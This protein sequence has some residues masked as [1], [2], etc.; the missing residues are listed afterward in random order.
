MSSDRSNCKYDVCLSFA[1]E[2]R[3][4]VEEVA[5]QARSRN[6][7]VFYD[8]YE[9]VEL[10][11]KNLYKHLA[12]VYQNQARFC[13]IFI[14]E[15]YARKLW[16]DHELSSAQARAFQEHEDYLLPVRFDDTEIPGV[17]RTIGY[18]NGR[19]VS[20]EKLADM[21]EQRVMSSSRAQYFPDNP[22]GLYSHL[23]VNDTEGQINISTSANN[24]FRSLKLM[25]PEELDVVVK[26][27]LHACPGE[28]PENVHIQQDLLSRLTG[29]TVDELRQYLGGISSLGFST[30]ER[31]DENHGYLG[32][33]S[34]FV[35][36][37]H[38]LTL[39][40][41]H[42]ATEVAREAI[43]SVANN[44]CEEHTMQ[45]LM[46]LDFSSLQEER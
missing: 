46:R 7:H 41:I 29:N 35:L 26:F 34:M 10:W 17:L 11:G 2:D 32:E 33:C 43:C 38:D 16:T 36:E 14:S 28:L 1:G 19:E 12:D 13:V 9:Q 44:Y 40:G 8:K 4:Y 18:I 30:R 25:K 42:E 3:E 20:P 15:N 23:E 27:F 45:A 22:I 5:S 24:F 37:W 39:D 21:I 6:I 31:V